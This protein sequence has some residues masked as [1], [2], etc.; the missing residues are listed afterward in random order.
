MSEYLVILHDAEPP[1]EQGREHLRKELT[2]KL[3]IGEDAV[4]EMFESLPVILKE[5]VTREHA[6]DF[7]RVLET[8]GANVEILSSATST[9]EYQAGETALLQVSNMSLESLS[10]D[11]PDSGSEGNESLEDLENI[12]N[13]MLNDGESSPE[14]Q[15]CPIGSGGVFAFARWR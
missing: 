13:S 8:M 10:L 6:E 9:G 3:G 2:A 14:T 12:L 15:R 7:L 11:A 4:R 5:H 1:T